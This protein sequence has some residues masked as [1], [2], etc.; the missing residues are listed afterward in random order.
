M[1]GWDAFG[2][3]RRVTRASRN[4]LYQVDGQSALELYKKYLGEHAKDLPTSGLLF[5]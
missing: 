5:P 1:G 3:E 4:V 2:P